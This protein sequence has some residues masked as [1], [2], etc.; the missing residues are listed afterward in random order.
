ME[1]LCL[2]AALRH[3]TPGFSRLKGSGCF[4]GAL[5]CQTRA[6]GRRMRLWVPNETVFRDLKK[7][8]D[9]SK[10]TARLRKDV[11][12]PASAPED[13]IDE[14]AEKARIPSKFQRG[15]SEIQAAIDRQRGEVRGRPA[16][17][18]IEP[19]TLFPPEETEAAEEDVKPYVRTR[20]ERQHVFHWGVGN[21]ARSTGRAP[22]FMPAY[23]H[24]PKEVT[25]RE[26]YFESDNPNIV[27]ESLNECWEVCWFENGKLTARPFAVKKHGIERAKKL[28][29]AYYDKLKS[30]GKI[31]PAPRHESRMEG[32]T[33]DPQLMCW[34]THYRD[35]LFP[36]SKAFSAEIHGFEGAR[37][38]ALDLR[39]DFLSRK[40]IEAATGMSGED[41]MSA[42]RERWQ[43]D[44]EEITEEEIR[45]GKPWP[46]KQAYYAPGPAFKTH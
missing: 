13:P 39:L 32:V 40:E 43:A 8:K 15:V 17:R 36:K 34:V 30:D 37:A 27:W 21:K 41:Q 45:K 1:R 44:A 6:Y 10:A 33:W 14:S 2:Q 16:L 22:Q 24:R 29:F 23:K 5:F 4:P 31:R 11:K 9:Q 26:D 7:F 20:K 12:R 25:I 46:H 35:G 3:R 38:L 42:L 18:P 19:G 28:A